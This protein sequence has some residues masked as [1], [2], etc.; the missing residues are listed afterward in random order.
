MFS[1]LCDGGHIFGRILKKIIYDANLV[2]HTP[3]RWLSKAGIAS[4][5]EVHGWIAEGRLTC[6]GVRVR[7]DRPVGVSSVRGADPTLQTLPPF[8]LDGR[9]LFPPPPLLLRF[10]KPRGVLVSLSDTEGRKVISDCLAGTPWGDPSWGRIRPLGRLDAAS[11][12]LLL[13]TNY[14]ERWDRF[15]APEAGVRRLYRVKIRPSLSIRDREL[16]L[17]GRAGEAAG[18]R[19]IGVEEESSKEKSSWL[20]I[21]L[22]EGKNREIRN[23]LAFYGYEVLHLIRQEFGPFLLGELLPGTM[24]DATDEAGKAGVVWGRWEVSGLSHRS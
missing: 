17:S 16:F 11:A 2:A 3:D 13:L 21:S 10:N 19:R 9:P 8:C 12:G 7:A 20:R 5:S 1:V 23:F 22:V 6:G 24:A 14:P 4:R 15:L 18:Y